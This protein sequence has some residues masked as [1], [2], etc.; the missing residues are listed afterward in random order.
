VRVAL[1]GRGLSRGLFSGRRLGRKLG[2]GCFLRQIVDEK[3]S[4]EGGLGGYFRSRIGR[5]CFGET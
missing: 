3:G 4:G 1:L 5:G 2:R